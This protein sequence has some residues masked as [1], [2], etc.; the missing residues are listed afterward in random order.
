MTPEPAGRWKFGLLLAAAVAAGTVVRLWMLPGQILL[1]DEWHG[2]NQVAGSSFR[3]VL[4]GFDAKDNTS[5]PLNVYHW[6][7]LHT[8]GWSELTIRLPVILAGILGLLAM[9]LA[10]RPLAG[11]RTALFFAFLLAASPFAVFYSRFSRAYAIILLLGFLSVVAACRWL[12]SGERRQRR[13]FVLYG[14]FA[15]YTH[16][17]AAVSLAV[18]FVLRGYA[19]IRNARVRPE[20]SEAVAMVELR[21]TGVMIVLLLVPLA[22]GMLTANERLPWGQGR[23]TADGLRDAAELLSGTSNLPVILI[24]FAALAGGLVSFS[25][26]CPVVA[27]AIVAA[28]AL[29]AAL[30][31]VSRPF[32]L[33]TG[34]V[35]LRYMIVILPLA[36]LAVAAGFDA[37]DRPAL[38]TAGFAVFL[39]LAVLSGPICAIYAAPNNFTNHSA[40]QGSYEPIDDSRADARHVYPGYRMPGEEVPAFYRQLAG[41]PGAA[42]ILEYPLDVTNYNNLFWF[43]QRVHKKGVLAGYCPDGSVLGYTAGF[44]PEKDGAPPRLGLLSADQ[45]LSHVGDRSKLRFANMVD[46]TDSSAIARSGAAYLVIHKYVMALRFLPGGGNDAVPVYYSSTPVIA[47]RFAGSYGPPVWEDGSIVCFRIGNRQDPEH[48]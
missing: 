6:V 9:P 7:L 14:L 36:L 44:P 13:R 22:W 12:S 23:W 20:G 16:P 19:A 47:A 11:D 32:G 18:P 8:A 43:Y 21:K 30:L 37:I 26:K 3:E 24:F 42:S 46:V 48:R 28:A 39:L 31:A 38:R 4:T 15:A 35:V 41:E 34:V 10:A 45:I 27:R 29:Y 1:D 2:L 17:L 5:L 33:G 25:K 40:Y